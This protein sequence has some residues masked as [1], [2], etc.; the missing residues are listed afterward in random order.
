MFASPFAQ[1][2][3][4]IKRL[5]PAVFL[6]CLLPLADLIYRGL[7]N[8]LDADPVDDITAVTGT[9][10][11]RLLLITLAVSPVRQVTGWHALIKLRRM[12]GLFAFFYAC[13]H[14]LTYLMLDQFFAWQFIVEDISER[15]YILVGFSA[16]VLLVPLAVTSTNGWV[17][18]LG[19]RRWQKLHALVYGIA[20]LGV[21]HHFLQVKADISGPAQYALILMVLLAYRWYRRRG[22]QAGKTRVKTA[23]RGQILKPGVLSDTDV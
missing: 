13:L 14:F 12:F 9:W 3:L 23:E 10:G 15:P 2:A 19:G 17:R 18:R 1:Q 5:K 20:V 16:F 4:L 6:L 22:K 8:Q 11:L 21:L 7:T